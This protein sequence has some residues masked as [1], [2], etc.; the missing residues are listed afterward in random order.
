[1]LKSMVVS[2]EN[3]NV[4]FLVQYQHF[5]KLNLMPCEQIILYC[6]LIFLK[7]YSLFRYTEWLK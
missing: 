3:R 2:C 7:N 5:R 4:I 6:A 1:V